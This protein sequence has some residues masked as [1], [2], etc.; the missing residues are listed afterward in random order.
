[1]DA[2]SLLREHDERHGATSA[3]KIIIQE[4]VQA[5]A[6]RTIIPFCPVLLAQL[7]NL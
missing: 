5:E 2:I 7:Y 6:Q 4:L 3:F 1:M